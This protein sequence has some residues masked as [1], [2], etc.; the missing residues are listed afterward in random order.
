MPKLHITQLSEV[1]KSLPEVQCFNPVTS[2]I[3]KKIDLFLCVLGFEERCLTIPTALAEH[4]FQAAHVRYCEY[5]TNREDNETNRLP[6]LQQLKAISED[7]NSFESDDLKFTGEFRELIESFLRQSEKVE[8]TI[9]FDISVAANRLLMRCM[10]V[11]LEFNIRLII[12]YSEAA[13]Y[14][15]TRAEYQHDPDRWAS[16]ET[17]GIERGVK[18]VEISEEYQGHHSDQLPNCV[19]L[20]PS[21]KKVRCR[22]IIGEVDPLLLASP[23]NNVIWLL[24]VSHSGQDEW[25]L[26]AIR[27]INDLGDSSTQYEVDTF[28]YRDALSKLDAIYQERIEQNKLTL[29]PMGS[30]MQTLGAAL[31]CYLRPSVRVMLATPEEYNALQYSEG[32]KATWMVEFGSLS[33]LRSKLDE[34]GMLRIEELTASDSKEQ[35]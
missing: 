16:D 24:G 18:E 5:A 27:K 17:L 4:G 6:L 11:L 34:V 10:K 8:P 33:E 31:F 15:P 19:M 29:A 22:T 9:M 35:E 26:E 21:I 25:R 23:D 2:T 20:F 7:V 30:N 12:L 14:H 1:I 13:I 28:D 3:D 32:C